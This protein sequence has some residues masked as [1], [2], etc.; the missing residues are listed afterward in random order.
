MAP[1]MAPI[2][3]EGSSQHLGDSMAWMALCHCATAHPGTTAPTCYITCKSKGGPTCLTS[4]PVGEVT[5]QPLRVTG[6]CPSTPARGTKL[7]ALQA[8]HQV[9][10]PP[11]TPAAQ[12]AGTCPRLPH[13]HY[14]ALSKWP[15][16]AGAHGSSRCGLWLSV[17]SWPHPHQPAPAWRGP[18]CSS[19][20]EDGCCTR[21]GH[22]TPPPAA[23]FGS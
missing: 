19:G 14:P 8:T 11:G 3:I 5:L 20:G 2:F 18:V 7:A 21:G 16:L 13:V 22:S 12:G 4:S 23:G 10:R 1:H 17:P 9:K 15:A 6:T